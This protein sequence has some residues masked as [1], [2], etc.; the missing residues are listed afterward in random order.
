[1]VQM[2]GVIVLALG[3]EQVF[4]SIDES[5]AIDN[6]VAVAGYVVMRVPMIFLWARAARDD[7]AHRPAAITY[8]WTIAVAQVCWV[9]LAIVA[10]PIGPTLALFAVFIGVEIVGPFVAERRKGGTPWH[11]DHIAERYGL[12]VIITLGE[13]I[14]GTVASINAVVHGDAGWTVEAGVVGFAGVGLIFATW[15]TYFLIP[16]ARVLSVHRERLFSGATGTSWSSPHSRRSAGGSTSRPTTSNI[17]RRWNR[18]GPP[19]HRDPVCDLHRH[20]VCPLRGVHSTR[21]PVPSSTSDRHDGRSRALRRTRRSGR[22]CRR[23]L[24]GADVRSGRNGG[25]V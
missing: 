21:G 7:P 10:L 25:G 19:Q 16:W 23:V 20:A 5:G 8:I 4:A 14:I 15:W 3:L 24:A 12:L 9:G 22:R 18:W 2:V 13:G 6:R 17:R 1:M 11:A